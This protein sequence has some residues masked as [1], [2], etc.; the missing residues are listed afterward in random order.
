MTLKSTAKMELHSLL[1]Q[2]A[3]EHGIATKGPLSM[4]LVVTRR[5]S[6]SGPPFDE[7]EFVTKEEGQV[8]GLGAA[9]V[10]AILEDHGVTRVL[11]KEGGRTSRGNMGRMRSYLGFLS[12]LS[13]RGLLDFDLIEA[14][15]VARVQDY[16][17]A[18]PLILKADPAMSLRRVIG[19]LV[20]AAYARQA[21]CPG[22]MVAG[23]VMQ[24]LVGAKLE[25]CFP[26]AGIDHRGFSVAD[27]AAGEGADF[28]VGDAAIHV[29]TAPTSALL[30]KCA[31]NLGKGLRPVVVTT[32]KG[33]YAA[34]AFASDAGIADRVDVLDIEQFLAT[35]V[36]EWS[37]FEQR[38]RSASLDQLVSAYNDIIDKC[39]TDAS[40]K[41][42]V[43]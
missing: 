40:L 25:I 3:E 35:N 41:I 16:F 42:A 2:F 30:S 43:A 22:T 26:N 7:A 38:S 21:E 17:A 8:A 29:T 11:A 28:A 13:L 36:Y 9:A 12:D 4:V 20:R 1:L 19:E 23:A 37:G 27:D 32:T 24:H 31:D 39:E 34:E 33:V 18:Q 15:W 14:W 10:Q 5:A 6:E